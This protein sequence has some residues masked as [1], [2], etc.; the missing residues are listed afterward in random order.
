MAK[1]KTKT[2]RRQRATDIQPIVNQASKVYGVP[3]QIINAV[4]MQESGYNPKAVSHVGAGGLMQLMP[5]TAKEL[6]VKDRF[7]PTENIFGGTKYLAQQFKTFGNWEHALAAYNAGPGRVKQY[8]GVPPKSFAKGETHNYVKTIISNLRSGNV[9]G[10]NKP[11]TTASQTPTTDPLAGITEQA[12]KAGGLDNLN[13]DEVIKGTASLTPAEPTIPGQG[14]PALTPT[15]EQSTGSLSDF[16]LFDIAEEPVKVSSL[17]T[18]ESPID[19]LDQLTQQAVQAGGIDNIGLDTGIIPESTQQQF[20][21]TIDPTAGLPDSTLGAA[22]LGLTEVL[23]PQGILNLIGLGEG[24]QQ[25]KELGGQTLAN[26][27]AQEHNRQLLELIQQGAPL[28]T[29]GG[30][31]AVSPVQLQ[32][33]QAQRDIE[34]ERIKEENPIA[35][36]IGQLTGFVAGPGKLA[37]PL[38]GLKAASAAQKVAKTAALGAAEGALFEKTIDPEAG[39]LEMGV[40]AATGAGAGAV[41]SA[42]GPTVKKIHDGLKSGAFSANIR[43]FQFISNALDAFSGAEKAR[44]AFEIVKSNVKLKNIQLKETFKQAKEIM[45]DRFQGLTDL[46]DQEAGNMLK[47]SIRTLDR[48]VSQRYRALIDPFIEKNADLVLDTNSIIGKLDEGLATLTGETAENLHPTKVNALI[49]NL[50]TEGNREL[51]NQVD[52]LWKYRQMLTGSE[53]FSLIGFNP[54]FATKPAQ[55]TLADI[56]KLRKVVAQRAGYEIAT[57]TPGSVYYDELYHTIRESI[58]DNIE[59][60]LGSDT[61][62]GFANARAEISKRITGFKKLKSLTRKDAEEIIK[63]QKIN[64]TRIDEIM[65]T[66]PELQPQLKAVIMQKFSKVKS[67]TQFDKLI[68]QYGPTSL[69]AAVGPQTA[70]KLT[71]MREALGKAVKGPKSR[72]IPKPTAKPTLTQRIA[73]SESAEAFVNIVNSY[74]SLLSESQKALIGVGGT[75]AV[76]PSIEELFLLNN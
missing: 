37:K 59:N 50:R 9:F 28:E 63:S 53:E 58:L 76:T 33:A 45:L 46:T 8:G 35:T 62:Q 54:Q 5:G 56:E 69:I 41:L 23:N 11:F 10:M 55:N 68:D 57:N 17:I 18:A 7:N 24:F 1:K 38:Q 14:T 74:D 6:G 65:E 71:R 61:A 47:E 40:G 19:T 44:Q 3:T 52:E 48:G 20:P 43:K 30:A 60:S 16:E 31:R 49:K 72:A 51:A 42:A 39:A 75:S 12:F 27:G 15:Q 67:I 21:P 66:N 4:I 73:G 34:L 13:L 64:G 2:S 25:S 32:E 22:G 26:I 70:R 36:L 29:T